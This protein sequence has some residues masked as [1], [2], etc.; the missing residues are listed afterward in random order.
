MRLWRNLT[1]T[2]TKNCNIFV[3]ILQLP[4]MKLFRVSRLYISIKQSNRLN[5]IV[6]TYLRWGTV[7]FSRRW[8]RACV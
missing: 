6:T 8:A 4:Y 2:D 3:L 7:K 5:V 1:S